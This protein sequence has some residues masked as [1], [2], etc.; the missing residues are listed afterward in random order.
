MRGNH[1]ALFMAVAEELKQPLMH[2]GRRAELQQLV[3]DGEDSRS[4]AECLMEIQDHADM[5]VS[6]LDAYLGGLRRGA[7]DDARR[8]PVCVSAVLHDAVAELRQTAADYG[9]ALQ[10]HAD[11]RDRPVLADKNSLHMAIVSLGKTLIQALPAQSGVPQR[12]QLASHRTRDGV[13]AGVYGPVDGLTA[14][15][16]RQARKTHG[17]VRQPLVG[18]LPGSAAG[19]FVAEALL[20]RMEST[21][22]VGRF[23]NVPGFAVTLPVSEQLQII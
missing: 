2:I 16:F 15:A 22:R 11:G 5:A 19:V 21:L 6:L 13:V 8:E 3:S 18:V 1:D 4:M 17:S 23:R 7:M 9:V 12:V 10:L 20:A 14:V